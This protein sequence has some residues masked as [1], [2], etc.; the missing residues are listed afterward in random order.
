MEPLKEKDLQHLEKAHLKNFLAENPTK[1]VE[2]RRMKAAWLDGYQ[3]GMIFMGAA[4][5][6]NLHIA[7]KEITDLTTALKGG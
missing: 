4:A 6:D 7:V 2:H 5:V 3:K 1:G